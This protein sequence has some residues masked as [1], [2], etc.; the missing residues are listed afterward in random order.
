MKSNEITILD[1]DNITKETFTWSLPSTSPFTKELICA[2]Y[3]RNN[4]HKHIIY[5]IIQLFAQ[6][7]STD[8]YSVKDI[9]QNTT[10]R[11]RYTSPIFS[12][13]NDLFHY[14]LEL[15]P[16]GY[17]AANQGDVEL[18]VCVCPAVLKQNAI[19]INGYYV[20]KFIEMNLT[21]G[22]PFNRH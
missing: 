7:Y 1:D 4:Y 2:G 13:H 12:V 5:D 3:T 18:F 21:A 15:W 17:R 14:Y 10:Y 11:S 8:L 22:S 19:F 16:N 6:F 20:I 9:L